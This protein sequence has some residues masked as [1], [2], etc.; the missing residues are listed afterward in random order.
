MSILE[1]AIKKY[2]DI[3]TAADLR[4]NGLSLCEME[5]LQLVL[6]DLTKDGKTETFNTSVAEWCRKNG[7]QVIDP[8]FENVNYTISL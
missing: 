4:K 6:M 2:K 3:D 5:I 8:N 1:K 7:L